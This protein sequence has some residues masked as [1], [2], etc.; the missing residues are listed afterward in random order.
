MVQSRDWLST[1]RPS[2]HSETISSPVARLLGRWLLAGLLATP[3]LTAC[4]STQPVGRIVLPKITDT[5]DPE[6]NPNPQH[7]VRLHGTAPE[8]LHFKL[9]VVYASTNREGDCW[10]HAAFFDGGGEKQWRYVIEPVREGES[11][12]AD[13]TVDRYLPGRCG[14]MGGGAVLAYVVPVDAEPGESMLSGIGVITRDFRDID[15]SKP[16]CPPR[17]RLCKEDRARLLDND[18]E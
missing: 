2:V 15:V 3:A 7:I 5:S 11:W 17:E 8:S 9:S 14:W 12:K 10:N 4:Q 18:D 6:L 16:L 13:L 1:E